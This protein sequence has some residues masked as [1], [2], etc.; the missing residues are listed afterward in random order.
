[1]RGVR[2]EAPNNPASLADRP[3]PPVAAFATVL[4]TPVARCKACAGWFDSDCEYSLYIECLVLFLSSVYLSFGSAMIG[5]AVLRRLGCSGV[6]SLAQ[7]RRPRGAT[8]VRLPDSPPETSSPL[9]L[10]VARRNAHAVR[11]DSGCIYSSLY[12]WSFLPTGFP[13]LGSGHDRQRTPN[14]GK[15]LLRGLSRHPS[16]SGRPVHTSVCSAGTG[17]SGA[18][19]RL[20][21]RTS[22]EAFFAPLRRP[23]ASAPLLR[24]SQL[25]P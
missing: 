8:L 7:H 11:I 4:L 24:P 5:I 15:T 21:F 16:S 14:E 3:R 13:N 17:E 22:N 10:P 19:A 6:P 12:M 9:L 23:V 2:R 1:M 20:A 25:H 18:R